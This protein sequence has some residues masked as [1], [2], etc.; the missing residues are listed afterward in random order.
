MIK[1]P[2]D[3]KANTPEGTLDIAWSDHGESRYPFRFLRENCECA[4]CVHEITGERLLVVELI[5]PDIHIQKMK[6]VGNYAIKIYWSDGHDT[7]L[8]TWER[9]REL[10]RCQQC[11]GQNSD[12]A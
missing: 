6:L 8:F 1:P 4:R 11:I 5:P 7:G 10:C 2:R 9:L 3:L 12:S